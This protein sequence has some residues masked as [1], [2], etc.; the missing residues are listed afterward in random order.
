VVSVE[1]DHRRHADTGWLVAGGGDPQGTPLLPV[2][3]DGQVHAAMLSI[4]GVERV[5]R[6]E[7]GVDIASLLPAP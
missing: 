5:L 2:L 4:A 6:D 3:H 1:G 7:A